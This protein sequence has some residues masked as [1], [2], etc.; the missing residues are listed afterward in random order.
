MVGGNRHTQ[1]AFEVGE[2]IVATKPCFIAKEKQHECKR[3]GLGDDGEIHTFDTRTECKV[4]KDRREQTRCQND[5]EQSRDET[6]AEVPMPRQGL[7]IQ[8][9]HEVGQF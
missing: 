5:Q 6:V 8:K 4:T 1:Y 9:H 3:H 7:P 2:P